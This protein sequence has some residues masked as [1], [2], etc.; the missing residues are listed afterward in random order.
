M[1]VLS[2]ASVSVM[3]V[4]HQWHDPKP[5]VQSNMRTMY[6]F[7]FTEC[8]CLNCDRNAFI[9]S[10]VINQVLCQRLKF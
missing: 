8:S 10:N 9:S 2:C 6:R 7:S 1:V 5:R 4:L 3:S